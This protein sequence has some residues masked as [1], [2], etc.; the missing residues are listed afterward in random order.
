MQFDESDSARIDNPKVASLEA[1]WN[2]FQGFSMIFEHS[3]QHFSKSTNDALR[4][5]NCRANEDG[6]LCLY[7]ALYDIMSSEH[8][9]WLREF[10]YCPLPPESFHVTVWDGI[11]DANLSQLPD[12]YLCYVPGV[13]EV[14]VGAIRDTLADTDDATVRMW[15]YILLIGQQL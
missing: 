5:L 14:T 4:Y 6:D 9:G 1:C 13:G 2:P 8:H 7:S 15:G 12:S 10:G 11:N 3:E